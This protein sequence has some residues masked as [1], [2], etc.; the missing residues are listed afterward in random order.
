MDMIGDG[1]IGG[2]PGNRGGVNSNSGSPLQYRVNPG[3]GPPAGKSSSELSK[4]FNHTELSPFNSKF[5]VLKFGSNSANRDSKPIAPSL[6]PF[7]VSPESSNQNSEENLLRGIQSTK[8]GKSIKPSVC[9]NLFK[10]S[11]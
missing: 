9:K 6:R 8:I 4:G 1:L 2:S 3:S 5:T 11:F 10:T 7:E